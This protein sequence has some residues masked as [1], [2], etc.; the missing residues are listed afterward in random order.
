MQTLQEVMHSN[1][2]NIWIT[3]SCMLE[4]KEM[5]WKAWP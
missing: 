4:I 3:F 5:K 1:V 2:D